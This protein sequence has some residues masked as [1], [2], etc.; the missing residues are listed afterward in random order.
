MGEHV[1]ELSSSCLLVVTHTL[2]LGLTFSW[3][4]AGLLKRSTEMVSCSMLASSS[5][6]RTLYECGDSLPCGGFTI[7]MR[8]GYSVVLVQVGFLCDLRTRES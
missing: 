8:A 4:Q 7:S 2:P 1:S 3:Y 5:A 6:M